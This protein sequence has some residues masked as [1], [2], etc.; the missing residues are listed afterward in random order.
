MPVGEP[1]SL[2]EALQE[3]TLKREKLAICVKRLL[4]MILW[5]E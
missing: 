1:N 2:M 5:L 4:E 3:G